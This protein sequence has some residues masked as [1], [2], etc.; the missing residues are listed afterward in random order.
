MELGNGNSKLRKR[1]S[2]QLSPSLD[3]EMGSYGGT[4]DCSAN[5]LSPSSPTGQ[6]TSPSDLQ[7]SSKEFQVSE[8]RS[9]LFFFAFLPLFLLFVY[10]SHTYELS[11][12]HLKVIENCLAAAY[13]TFHFATYLSFFFLKRI[14]MT[15][16][17]ITLFILLL[18]SII[19]VISAFCLFKKRISNLTTDSE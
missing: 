12:Q 11:L 6:I 8:V 10:L 3:T 13:C 14:T 7:T 9:F 2:S 18:Y 5:S 19:S 15:L 1:Q 17:Q 4:A 16:K